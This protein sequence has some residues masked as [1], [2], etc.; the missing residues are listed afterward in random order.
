MVTEALSDDVMRQ[1]WQ[2]DCLMKGEAHRV[3]GLIVC[4]LAD[5]SP[6]DRQQV[7]TSIF[8]GSQAMTPLFYPK[9]KATKRAVQ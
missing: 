5:N 4:S 8:N 6:T 1:F 9:G 2:R 3:A 7:E